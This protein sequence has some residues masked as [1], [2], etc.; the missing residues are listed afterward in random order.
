MI[1]SPVIIPISEK[2]PRT[3]MVI[4]ALREQA[5]TNP[6]DSLDWQP[7]GERCGVDA[8]SPLAFGTI[9]GPINTKTVRGSRRSAEQAAN[10]PLCTY[11]D[12]RMFEDTIGAL[13]IEARGSKLR[14]AIQV[15]EVARPL[16][17]SHEPVKMRAAFEIL[18]WF[19]R[20]VSDSER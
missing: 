5:E 12:R 8:Y 19:V 16:L 15:L 9:L 7:L 6:P 2:G 4:E 1:H 3:K 10:R 18:E 13:K 14:N 11:E 20:G 17:E